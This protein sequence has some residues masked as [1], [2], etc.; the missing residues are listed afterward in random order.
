MSSYDACLLITKDGGDNFGI[1]GLQTDDILNIRTEAFI[2]KK[3][4]EIIEDKLKAKNRTILETGVSGDFN[5]CRM[6][7][8]AESIMVVKKNQAEKLVLVDIKDNAK[9]Q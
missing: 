8:G 7:I 1:V 9:K 4:K 5:S 3:E 6:T 2:K